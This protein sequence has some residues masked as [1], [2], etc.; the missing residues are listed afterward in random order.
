MEQMKYFMSR[1][2]TIF[3][4]ILF[5]SSVFVILFYEGYHRIYLSAN[6]YS[7]HETISEFPQNVTRAQSEAHGVFLDSVKTLQRRTFADSGNLDGRNKFRWLYK[8]A[9]AEVYDL[10]ARLGGDRGPII[11]SY[12][13]YLHYSLWAL[14]SFLFTFLTVS[15]LRQRAEFNVLAVL[16]IVY[17]AYIAFLTTTPNMADSHS[18]IEMATIAAGLHFSLHRRI[19]AF[20]C[21]LLVAVVNRETGAMLGGIYAVINWW[22]PG[23]WIPLVLGPVMLLAINVDLML[24]PEFYELSSYVY[25]GASGNVHFFNFWNLPVSYVGFSFLKNL[26]V[27]APLVLILPRVWRDDLARRLCVIGAVYL[28]ILLFGTFIGNSTPYELLVPVVLFLGSLAFPRPST[29]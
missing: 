22:K 1:P 18:I 17:F 2:R 10:V 13:R 6:L 27:I 11:A 20:L 24:L 25:T 8:S 3:I 26:V 5:L 9:E 23:F 19:V 4:F 29:T 14:V 21:V 7:T 28:C 15:W 16:A 12:V